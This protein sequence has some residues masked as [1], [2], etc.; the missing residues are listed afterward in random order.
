MDEKKAEYKHMIV[1]G[2]KIGDTIEIEAWLK[3]AAL[4]ND[5]GVLVS[6]LTHAA[7]RPVLETVFEVYFPDNAIPPEES[8]SK[9]ELRTFKTISQAQ[10][11]FSST[12]SLD[13]FDYSST[14]KM[15]EVYATGLS[16]SHNI[17]AFDM[18]PEEASGELNGYVA[19]DVAKVLHMKEMV[20]S[21][22]AGI[23]MASVKINYL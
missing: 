16:L 2:N 10:L 4:N 23:T 1:Y 3:S 17:C 14:A 20:Q 8:I 21:K 6:E 13:L 12:P 7:E 5:I 15:I 11:T 22:L 9:L 19:G 18:E